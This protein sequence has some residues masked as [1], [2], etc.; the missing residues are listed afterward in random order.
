MKILVVEDDKGIA[1]GLRI[2]LQHRG[3]KV[4]VCDNI[5]VAWTALTA[6]PFDMV[7]LDLGLPDG[8]GSELLRRVRAPSVPA[9]TGRACPTPPRPCSS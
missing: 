1:S 8:D 3:Y 4:S 9:A 6:E 7:L 2:T 5:A